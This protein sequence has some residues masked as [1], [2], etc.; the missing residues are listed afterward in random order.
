LYE[1]IPFLASNRGGIPEL[2]A[3]A[4]RDRVLAPAVA[5]QFASRL[6]SIL[7]NTRPTSETSPVSNGGVDPLLPTKPAESFDDA[8]RAWLKWHAALRPGT[9]EPAQH[10]PKPEPRI[11]VCIAHY[12]RP[13]LLEQ[14]LE[15]LRH[16]TYSNFEVLLVDDGSTAPDALAYLDALQDEFTARGWR[17]LRQENSGPGIARD[18]AART[19]NSSYLLFA[20]DDDVLL[21][22]TLETFARAAVGSGADAFT[23]ILVEFEGAEP[24]E[25]VSEAALLIPLGAALGPGLLYPEFGGTLIFLKR[26]CYFDV[27]GFSL[28]R[29]VDED[30]ELLLTIVAKG[31]D[32]RAIPEPLIFYRKQAVSRSRADNRFTRHR[33]R[34]RVYEKMLP[35]ELRDLA[36][37]AFGRLSNVG[38]SGAQRRLD[39]LVKSLENARRARTPES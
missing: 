12:Q 39:R 22:N 13:A 23:G 37:L 38:D 11:S 33:N 2:V 9:I 18:L 35:R 10:S 36:A 15:S 29:D 27:G 7:T 25:Q 3:P 24:P 32:L 26:Q 14:M 28:E 20:D 16:Q 4:D 17:L 19:A 6:L 8:G 1:G 30:W 21:P 31:F 34:L 5:A